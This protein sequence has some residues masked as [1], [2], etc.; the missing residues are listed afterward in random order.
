M[1][2]RQDDGRVVLQLA[3]DWRQAASGTEDE[4][5]AWTQ[6]PAEVTQQPTTV[7]LDA[8]QVTDWDSS[9][10]A[11][12]WGLQRRLS[13]QGA[14]LDLS[15]APEGLRSMLDLIAS[16][17]ADAT[18]P[19]ATPSTGQAAATAPS[20]QIEPPPRES[21]I[22]VAF[23]GEVLLAI[24]RWLRGRSIMPKDEL[25]RQIDFT[26]PRSMPIVL[27][28][29]AL[30]GLMLAYMGGA[31]LMS[32][33]AQTYIAQV[34]AIGLVREMAGLIMAIILA[35]RL[36]ASFAAQIGTMK[37]N[38]EIDALRALGVDP[39]S[40]LVLPRLFALM[41]IAPALQVMSAFVGVVAAWPVATGAY[42]VSSAEYW[43]QSWDSIA[44]LDVVV[45]QIKAMLYVI[46]VAIAG[47]REG[48]NAGRDAQAVG[49]ATT[50]AVVKS[51]VWI[52]VAASATTIFF[53]TV[54]W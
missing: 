37:A 35:G 1:A 32:I 18:P 43:H 53:T 46:L 44:L 47:C 29:C 36:G 6:W 23:F 22:T 52:V 20:V 21:A 11:R 30:V 50:S 8:Q 51:L 31:Q 42:G 54:G 27:M 9:L 13:H 4:R 25:L 16:R 48:L 41:L 14:H 26:G 10:A 39:V 7:S 3:G 33:G 15:G 5:S 24:G 40:Y 34:V 17:T 49:A 2:W 38:E 45:G 19:S 28:S 12:L